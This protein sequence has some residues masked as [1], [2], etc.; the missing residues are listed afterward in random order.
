MKEGDEKKEARRSKKH[1][2]ENN[3]N[4]NVVKMWHSEKFLM[5]RL[6]LR[7]RKKEQNRTK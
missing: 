7:E 1:R 2:R 5:G 3:R 6:K 4:R